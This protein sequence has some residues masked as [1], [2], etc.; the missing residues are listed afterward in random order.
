[1]TILALEIKDLRK[2]YGD[3]KALKGIS[4]QIFK[5][6]LFSL[7]GPNG[8][9]KTTTLRIIS[10]LTTPTSG[11]IYI[12]GKDLFE[13]EL[14]AKRRIGLVPQQINL[15]LELTV[16]ENLFI[17]GLL[18]KMSL[19]EIKEK[20]EELLEMSDLAERRKSKVKE[21]SGGL[22]RRLL[23]VRA[24]MHSPELLLLDEPTVGLDPHIRRKIWSFIKSIQAKG[25]TILLTTHYME[26]AE[27]LSDRV[28]FI[29]KGEIVAID[30][31]S[32]FIKKLGNYAIDIFSDNGIN[33]QFFQTKEEAEET[34]LKLSQKYNYVSFRKIT[35]EDVFIKLTGERV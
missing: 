14:W 29:N 20:I 19:K 10:G 32:N 11:N 25:T 21:L 26:E 12:F 17:H 33:T 15:D 9:G 6:E 35:L 5:G 23:I 28:A 3:R 24:L 27:T 1:M 4:F 22:R 18:F 13:D 30:T 8:A 16:E 2:N 7:L 31:P 34:F